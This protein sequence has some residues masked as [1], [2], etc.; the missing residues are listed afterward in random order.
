MAQRI[1][2]SHLTN[3]DGSAVVPQKHDNVE[4]L[5]KQRQEARE[6]IER[7]IQWVKDA[8]QKGDELTA[9]QLITRL[10]YLHSKVLREDI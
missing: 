10:D 9:T 4:T 5:K 8:V 7:I 2:R 1:A 6:E 3:P